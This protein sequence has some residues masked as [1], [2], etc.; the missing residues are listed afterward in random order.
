MSKIPPIFAAVHFLCFTCIINPFEVSQ[1]QYKFV[2]EGKLNHRW[3]LDKHEDLYFL[4]CS[5][6]CSRNSECFGIA[7]GHLKKNR[8]DNKRS[9]YLLKNASESEQYC[10]VDD[11]DSEEVEIYEV[12]LFVFNI[13]SCSKIK[14]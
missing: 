1:I 10:P 12:S 6:K 5:Q 3:I 7:L 14:G 13:R 11:C 4:T 8:I 9:C 2:F